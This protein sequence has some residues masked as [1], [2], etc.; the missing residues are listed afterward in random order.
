MIQLRSMARNARIVR[1]NAPSPPLPPPALLPHVGGGS[2]P[3]SPLLT[4]FLSHPP[5]S[6]FDA[7]TILLPRVA[8][9]L[10]RRA[11]P[12]PAADATP[13]GRGCPRR[14]PLLPSARGPLL[15]H[16]PDAAPQAGRRRSC[17]AGHGCPC[18]FTHGRGCYASRPPLHA[19]LAAATAP[20]AAHGCPPQLT[21][22]CD[23]PMR[24]PRR[25]VVPQ[26]PTHPARLGSRSVAVQYGGGTGSHT[27][28]ESTPADPALLSKCFPRRQ[29]VR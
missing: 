23:S 6:F 20:L 4:L 13:A 15:P 21:S 7:Q 5:F 9:H 8:A 19:L 12:P 29:A 14:V 3:S 16:G 28:F 1:F 25:V 17:L 10:H 27:S 2:I 24:P 26:S 18:S 22:H 11:A